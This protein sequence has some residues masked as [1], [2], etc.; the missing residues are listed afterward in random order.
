MTYRFVPTEGHVAQ[1][2]GGQQTDLNLDTPFQ[3]ECPSGISASW[4]YTLDDS[5]ADDGNFGWVN[6][7]SG[8]RTLEGLGITLSIIN[9]LTKWKNKIQKL[10]FAVATG[11][12]PKPY[13]QKSCDWQDRSLSPCGTTNRNSSSMSLQW[14]WK[15]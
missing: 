8:E 7:P 1:F 10:L 3:L 6:M 9:S 11:F 4:Q 2:I 14:F 15:R 13:R 12:I 5:V